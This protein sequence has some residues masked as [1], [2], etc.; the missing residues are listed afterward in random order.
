IEEKMITGELAGL[1]STNAL[2]LGIDIGNLDCTVLAGYP[3]TRASFW[4][5]TG[6]AGRSKEKCVNY[7]ILE[8]QP[9]D[10]YIALDP[11]W[12]FSKSSENAIVDPDNLLIELAHIRAAAAEMP[13]SLDDAGLFP[14]LGEIIPV[15]L[16]AG[17]VESMAGR[18]AWAG[19]AFPA[20]GYSLRNMDKSRYKLLLETDQRELTQMD[21]TQAFHELY[22]GA[23]YIHE[24]EL[25]EV[26]KLD[27][28]SRTAY[29]VPFAGNYYTVPSGTQE[30][31]ILQTFREEE[32]GRSRI[33]FGDI[34]VEEVIS[35]YKKLQFH[36]QDRKSTRLNSSHVS[37]SYAVFCLKKKKNRK[38][39]QEDTSDLRTRAA[40]R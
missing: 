37:I 26:L 34:N 18:F 32:L 19:E 20:G 5:Q 27:L 29:G 17:E 4:Q 33:Y 39:Q 1:V 24:G 14:D 23:V 3:G 12:L 8:N 9:F 35:M 16:N 6:R 28:E 2:E 38:A 21:E 11:E 31:R 30:T 22:P 15:L 13:L 36:N 25:Y 40:R 7:L 10:Q